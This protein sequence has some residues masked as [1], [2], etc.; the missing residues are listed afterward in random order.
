VIG[1]GRRDLATSGIL[2]FLVSDRGPIAVHASRGHG[3]IEIFDGLQT[4]VDDG[5]IDVDPEGL[6]GLRLRRA[7]RQVDKAN[8]SGSVRSQAASQYLN[9]EGIE[10]G[11]SGMPELSGGQAVNLASVQLARTLKGERG[12]A[13]RDEHPKGRTTGAED[14]A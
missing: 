4:A 14:G 8:A 5:I 13:S 2:P 7:G 9:L 12:E 11:N 1:S 3:G 10:G 6:G